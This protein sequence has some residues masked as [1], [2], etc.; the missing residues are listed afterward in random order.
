M[1]HPRFPCGVPT[2]EAEQLVI[3]AD[4][5]WTVVECP[6]HEARTRWETAVREEKTQTIIRP[7]DAWRQHGT[8][9]RP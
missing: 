2:C 6:V 8:K 1:R 4:S 3:E 9:G 5:R 7:Q